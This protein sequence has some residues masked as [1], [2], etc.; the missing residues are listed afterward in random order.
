MKITAYF[1]NTSIRTK[2]FIVTILQIL[3]P[4]LSLGFILTAISTDII[5]KHSISHTASSLNSIK[6][7]IEDYSNNIFQ[8]SQ[9]L[10][11][12]SNIFDILTATNTDANF[13]GNIGKQQIQN[14]IQRILLSRNV[15]N[16]ASLQIANNSFQYAKKQNI[17]YSSNIALFIEIEKQ[18]KAQN[19]KPLWF[20]DMNGDNLDNIFF[21]RTIYD[22][23]KYLEKGLLIFQVNKDIFTEITQEFNTEATQFS[24]VSHSGQD[25]YVY[26]GNSKKLSEVELSNLANREYGQ[27]SSK[28][29][30]LM[31]TKMYDP[32]WY[33]ICNID[34]KLL[35]SDVYFLI[36]CTGLL[37]LLSTIILIIFTWFIQKEY[38]NP[39]NTLVKMMRTWKENETYKNVFKGR[40]DEIGVLF[41]NFKMMTERISSLIN[42]NYRDQI[43]KKETEIKMLQSQ[44]NPHFLF[45][46]LESINCVAQIND[47]PQISNMVT[48]LSDIM[49]QTMGRDDRLITLAREIEHV[50]NYFYIL[51]IRFE[52]KLQMKKDID[53]KAFI[54]KIPNII[55]QPIIEN[56]VYHGVMPSHK[57]G[58]IVLT[59]RLYAED[60]IITVVDNGIG[61]GEKELQELN[62]RFSVG[63]E[64]YFD[65]KKSEGNRIGLEN[66]NRRIKLL[67]GEEYGITIK[68]RHNEFTKVIL[69][70]KYQI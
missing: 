25:V 4:I 51:K 23:Y 19:G 27:I 59:A 41:H 14:A 48:A 63:N 11:Y 10:I 42:Q 5:K 6:S 28:R 44:I 65:K 69:K 50:D 56:A 31:F 64:S 36:E 9:E 29:H 52:D 17:N 7:K 62:E 12:D 2:I 20:L 53:K 58:K 67:Y 46:T 57:K 54:A 3:I 35:Y 33:V 30:Y 13:N 8:A 61:I 26:N 34:L 21:V 43:I 39:I 47:V 24:I 22:P 38:I 60:L 55:I 70:L 15:I 37:C 40:K 49:E 1:R 45:N 66:V 32:D 16:S 18:A 68:S